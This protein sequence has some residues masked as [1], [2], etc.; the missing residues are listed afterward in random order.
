[1]TEQQIPKLAAGLVEHQ[2]S[3][4]LLSVEDGQWVIQNTVEAIGLFVSA[5]GNRA[6]KLAAPP[7]LPAQP[8]IYFRELEVVPLGATP[9]APTEEEVRQVFAGYV[10]PRL[11]AWKSKSAAKTK[12]AVHQLVENGKFPDFFGKTA[13]ILERRRW[14]WAQVVRFCDDHPKHLRQSGYATFFLITV[15]GEPVLEDTSNVFVV[16][17]RVDD[18]GRL[19][20]FL[21][22]FSDDYVW[23]A[24][25]R[26][27]IV[28]PQQE[29]L[30]P[31]A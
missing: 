15:D 17:V 29:T 7:A 1:M 21:D 31:A 3:F 30:A 2:D 26:R 16:D 20:A 19:D 4:A 10:D 14:Q 27:R 24:R 8:K 9:T 5:V 11:L 12:V 22:S 25:Y 6:E 18:N 23:N 13:D 28:V